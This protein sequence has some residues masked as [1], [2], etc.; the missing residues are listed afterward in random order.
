MPSDPDNKMDELLKSYAKKRRDE[1]G[2]P[3]EMHPAT[4]RLLQAEIAK[5]RPEP[6]ALP[7]PWWQNLLMFWPRLAFATGV[8]IVLGVA[9]WSLMDSMKQGAAESQLARN[10][11]PLEEKAASFAEERESLRD[12]TGLAAKPV[13]LA[14]E[15]DA[16]SRTESLADLARSS[17]GGREDEGRLKQKVLEPAKTESGATAD[18]FSRSVAPSAPAVPT[19]PPA[20]TKPAMLAEQESRQFA[21]ANTPSP[22]AAPTKVSLAGEFQSKD[23]VTIRPVIATTEALGKNVAANEEV[24]LALAPAS[25][26]VNG[27]DVNLSISA[28]NQLGGGA[29]GNAVIVNS[30]GVDS[31]KPDNNSRLPGGV[32]PPTDS[33]AGQALGNSASSLDSFYAANQN[34]AASGPQA[35]KLELSL[36]DN[37]GLAPAR[38]RETLLRENSDPR[39]TSANDRPIAPVT[40][41]V[42]LERKPA[43]IALAGAKVASDKTVREQDRNAPAPTDTDSYANRGA[44]PGQA[45]QNGVYRQ[46]FAQVPLAG[47]VTVFKK[48][49]P[50]EGKILANFEVQ[51]SGEQVRV[52]DADGSV[53]DGQVVVDDAVGASVPPIAADQV[54]QQVR[55]SDMRQPQTPAIQQATTSG[56]DGPNWAFRVSGTNRTLR[57]PVSLEGVMQNSP[58][59]NQAAQ[60][61]VAPSTAQSPSQASRASQ[62][63]GQSTRQAGPTVADKEQVASQLSL[64][65]TNLYGAQRMQGRLRVGSTSQVQLE[66]V[67]ADK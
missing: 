51:R 54:R 3:P 30:Y 1:A 31:R 48:V 46:R 41:P 27:R 6:S 43:E 14:K 57:Q 16:K 17:V 49:A 61:Q 33:S 42:P 22:Q 13:E 12:D 23:N 20:A 50:T 45:A 28:N 64:S 2:D 65:V 24:R 4:R 25:N 7:V 63:P 9:A 36:P 47:Q 10:D 60:S 40:Q 18:R 29:A 32:L 52:V 56:T 55:R 34:K 35:P 67:P 39:A 62:L 5:L 11:R 66:A 38:N 26:L 21:P 44:A 58:F 19:Q 59:Q 53:Y 37:S 15:V 8:F